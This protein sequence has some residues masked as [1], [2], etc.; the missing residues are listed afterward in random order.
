MSAPTSLMTDAENAAWFVVQTRPREDARALENLTAQRYECF[1]PRCEVTRRIRGQRRTLREPLFPG[2]VFVRLH[3]LGHDWGPI[4]STRG[5]ARLVRFGS[6]APTLPARSI[7]GLREL[8]GIRLADPLLGLAP[9][10]K[11]QIVAGP[12][13]GMEAAFD[14]IDGERRVF[15]LLD[16]MQ[17]RRRVAMTPD[18]VQPVRG[19]ALA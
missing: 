2:Y 1:Q 14:C 10:D 17:R 18:M 13:A 19:L 5:V 7:A 6:E 16:W 9:G 3:R 11:V 15:V 4:R 12:L 8:D